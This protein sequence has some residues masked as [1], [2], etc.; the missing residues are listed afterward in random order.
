VTSNAAIAAII[1]GGLAG[2]ISKILSVKYLDLGALAISLFL[3]ISVSLIENRL[4]QSRKSL[5]TAAESD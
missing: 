1:G 5:R 3:L 4:R 2:L